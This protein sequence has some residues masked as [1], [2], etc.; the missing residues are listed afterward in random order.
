MAEGTVVN[1]EDKE[2][3]K[4]K[5]GINDT[6]IIIPDFFVMKKN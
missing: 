2:G 1:R 3:M 5:D 6:Y 4:A